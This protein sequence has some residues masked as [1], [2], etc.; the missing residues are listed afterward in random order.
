MSSYLA[1]FVSCRS[2]VDDLTQVD[3]DKFQRDPMLGRLR[4]EPDIFDEC[5]PTLLLPPPSEEPCVAH[6]EEKPPPSTSTSPENESRTV[7]PKAPTN[8]SHTN[9]T[10]N[11]DQNHETVTIF[12]GRGPKSYGQPSSR[13]ALIQ[14]PGTSLLKADKRTLLLDSWQRTR[15][16]SD[17]SPRVHTT[18]TQP[19]TTQSPQE[20]LQHQ[21]ENRAIIFVIYR[22]SPLSNL[23]LVSF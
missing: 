10:M 11:F 18:T 1:T 22:K 6:N 23:S 9:R 15:P 5:I 4:G 8:S 21:K 2:Q 12:F 16:P 14:V 20:Y 7:R 3:P 13:T 17:A 19:L